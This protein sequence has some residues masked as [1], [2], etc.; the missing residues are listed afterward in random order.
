[1]LGFVETQVQQIGN[2]VY[3]LN[4]SA[5]GKDNHVMIT[6]KRRNEEW[7]FH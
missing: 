1:M 6:R 7:M 5:D 3:S 4:L 2:R